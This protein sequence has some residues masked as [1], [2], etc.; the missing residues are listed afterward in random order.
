MTSLLGSI[1]KDLGPATAGSAN[2]CPPVGGVLKEGHETF[3]L[4]KI[5]PMAVAIRPS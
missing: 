3:N 4:F 5:K 1:V 2:Y